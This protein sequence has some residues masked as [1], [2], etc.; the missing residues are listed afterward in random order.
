MQFFH[1]ILLAVDAPVR[2]RQEKAKEPSFR[3]SPCDGR[4]PSK[5]IGISLNWS[6]NGKTYGLM[7]FSYGCVQ[8]YLVPQAVKGPFINSINE[9]RATYVHAYSILGRSPKIFKQYESL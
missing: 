6:S 3:S 8:L 1:L 7:Y 9:W 5:V 4:K 2:T